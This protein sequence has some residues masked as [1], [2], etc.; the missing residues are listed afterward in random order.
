LPNLKP[1]AVYLLLGFLVPGMIASFVRA[2]FITGRMP[3]HTDA[4][5]SYLALSI[6]YYALVF[7][8][9]DYVVSF[10]EPGYAK[11]L[12]WFVLVFVGPALLGFVLGL[13]T[14]MELGRRLLKRLRLNPVH[15]MPT[16]WD[17][18]FGSMRESWVLAV[19]K[20]GTKFA[21][22][23]GAGSFMSSD[24]KERDLYIERVYAFDE[25]NVW[26]PSEQGVLIGSGEIQ[27]IEFWPYMK[28]SNDEQKQAFYAHDGDSERLPAERLPAAPGSLHD[29]AGS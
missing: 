26:H 3:S 4:A 27:T 14:Q 20:D 13:T 28:E 22:F 5:L 11:A 17:W 29:R 1:D 19:L 9:V 24:P 15:V 6:I 23:C 10:R 7:P 25:Q 21:G 2:Q 16:A 8:F 12:A 18:K